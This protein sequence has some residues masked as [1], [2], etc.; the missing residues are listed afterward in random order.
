MLV[1]GGSG[2]CV[3]HAKS[4]SFN[5][6]SSGGAIAINSGTTLDL[7][8]DDLGNTF[9][10][11]AFVNSGTFRVHHRESGACVFAA[12]TTCV[13]TFGT[14]F[15]NSTNPSF[16]ITAVNPGAVTFT[17]TALSQTAATITASGSNS[18]TVNWDASLQ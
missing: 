8:L 18:L 17:V 1:Y 10:S 4:T 11:P 16:V 6:G 5:G 14:T 7:Y 12:A 9:S 3:I 15:G 13:V 2:T